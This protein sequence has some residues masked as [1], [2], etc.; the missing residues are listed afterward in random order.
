MAYDKSVPASSNDWDDDLT[1]MSENFTWL[2]RF[3]LSGF[4]PIDGVSIEYGYGSTYTDRVES[5]TVK[6][7][8][9][10]TIASGTL[11][12]DA[13]NTDQVNS[14]SWSIDG[15]NYAIAYTWSGGKLTKTEIT[16]T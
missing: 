12:Y 3:F 14:E 16:I 9:A 1:A 15:K 11:T 6:D 2:R 7:S 10:S 4:I 5:V 8:G 13:T